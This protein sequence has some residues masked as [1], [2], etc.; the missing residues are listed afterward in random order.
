MYAPAGS[1]LRNRSVDT[2]RRPDAYHWIERPSS[3]CS[4]AARMPARMICELNAPAR[5]RSPVTSSSPT[6][7]TFS[8]SSSTGRFGMFSAASAAWRVIRRI[9]LAYGRSAWMRCSAR[10]RRAAATISMARVIFSMFLTEEIR[11]LT[12]R[13]EPISRSASRVRGFLFAGLLLVG[14]RALVL[15]GVVVAARLG[16]TVLAVPVALALVLAGAV[17]LALLHRLAVLV[18]VAAEVVGEL[19]DE[20]LDLLDRGVL[21]VAL[22]DLLEQVADLGVRPLAQRVEVLG[23]AVDVD[24]VQVAVGRGVDLDDLVLGRQ[25]AALLLVERLH[26]AL[27]AGQRL[28]RVGVEV[29]AELREGLELAVLRQVEA[30]AAGDLLH[31][32]DLR[33]AAD[34]RHRDADV[35]GGADAR[36]EEAGLEEDLPVGDRDDV[37]RDVGRH[38]ARLRL[39]D[40]QRGQRPAAEIVVELAR[41]LQQAAVEIEDVARVG[42]ATRRA[43]QQ[44]RH[45]AIRVRVLGEVVVDAQRVLA[46]EE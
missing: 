11:F 7:C 29:G 12:S 35:D 25:R 16:T 43:A 27:A 44:Q 1:F 28:L 6:V 4:A 21:P 32:L 2:P 22:A 14:V 33:V 17:G 23:D 36:V 41:A 31:R 30:Q 15:L 18:E 37:G 19:L 3:S 45:L 42:L 13:W 10:R 34:A 26:Q 39:D 24:A 9:A 8:C 20:L 38:V 46:L 5:P 40:R